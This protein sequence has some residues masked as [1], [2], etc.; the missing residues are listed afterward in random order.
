MRNRKKNAGKGAN[1]P[2]SSLKIKG[3]KATIG[4]VCQKIMKMNA[5]GI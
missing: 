5:I 2:P 1:A 4:S 3:I